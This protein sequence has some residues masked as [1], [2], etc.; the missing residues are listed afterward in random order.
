MSKI[1]KKAFTLVELLVVIAIVGL[2]STV[3]VVATSSS[4]AKAKLA[5][6]QSFESSVDNAAGSEII[7][8]WLFDETSGTAANDSSGNGRHG[9][10][11]TGTRVS[12]INGNA[13]SFAS[14]GYVALGNDV[15]FTPSRF[16]ITAWIKPGNFSG[17]YNYIFSNARDCCG[18]YRG[19]EFFL[20][21]YTLNGTIWNNSAVYLGANSRIT[22]DPVWTF[23]A[24]SYDGA[25]MALYINGR[26]DATSNTALGVGS[27]E[28]LILTSVQWGRRRGAWG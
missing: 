14:S 8:E 18:A 19:I 4:R 1:Y 17:S 23:V 15:A 24:F 27:P 10:I 12:G 2:L 25:K 11:I 7:G 9:T 20:Y 22:N 5:A 28:V 6:S 16:T 3:A 26:L 21:N 13:L